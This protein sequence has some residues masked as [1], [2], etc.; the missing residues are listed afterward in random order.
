ML[1]RD[2]AAA[3]T[4]RGGAAA[5]PRALRVLGLTAR[6]FHRIR[7]WEWGDP[8]QARTA[9]CVHGLTRNGR[10]FDALA[11]ALADQYRVLCPDVAGRGES[12]WIDATDYAYPQYC[13]DMTNLIA[14]SGAAAVDWIGTSMGGIIGMILAAQSNSPIRRLVLND[15]GP[16]IP[17]SAQDAIAETVADNPAFDS[18]DAAADYISRVNAGFG[19]L[20]Q[21]DWRGLAR[22]AARRR[23]DG[24]YV[25]KRDP[26][27]GANFVK[28]P[29][30]DVAMWPVWDLVRCPV[31]VL[32]GAESALLTPSVAEEMS[33]RGPKARL[34]TIEGAGHAPALL[35]AREIA[36]IREFLLTP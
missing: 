12:D 15:V 3:K 24:K 31:L 11:A 22:S 10:D 36:P 5:G 26:A 16:F 6:G 4:P 13:A 35:S 21:D 17:K 32:R 19:R 25:W 9:I 23:E 30:D 28:Q 29:R 34:V 7:Y 33:R 1:R 18:L 14:R 8:A 27:I 20:T 2:P